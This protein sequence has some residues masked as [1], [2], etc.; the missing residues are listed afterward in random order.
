MKDK[1]R[2]ERDITAI[3]TCIT[4]YETDLAEAEKKL[5]ELEK[6]ELNYK[7]GDFGLAKTNLRSV[8]WRYITKNE[9]HS[10]Y[11][12]YEDGDYN[13]FSERQLNEIVKLG[14]IDDLKAM[15]E[16]LTEFI[17]KT[18]CRTDVKVEWNSHIPDELIIEQGSDMV[19]ITKTE[20]PEFILN[21]RRMQAG[22]GE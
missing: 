6:P 3:K 20:L 13:L 10:F 14:N 5:A 18:D 16:P 11:V 4:N 2:I 7:D 19:V 22:K 12:I 21:L 17:L 8:V 9:N 1:K 15:S